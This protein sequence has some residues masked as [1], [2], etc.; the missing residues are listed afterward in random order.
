LLSIGSFSGLSKILETNDFISSDKF[1]D[2]SR[3]EPRITYTKTD[4]L[5]MDGTWR[6]TLQKSL[7]S[8]ISELKDQVL[9]FGHADQKITSSE[10]KL[11]A[12]FS[13]AK[14]IFGTNLATVQ[15]LSEILPLGLTNNS[16]ESELH[17]VLGN[18]NHIA[19][20][21][22]LLDYPKDKFDF[23]VYVNFTIENNRGVRGKVYSLLSKLPNTYQL[24]IDNPSMSDEGRVNYLANLRRSNFVLCP[25][26]NGMDTH[27]LWETLYMGGVPVVVRSKYMD[28]LYNQLPLV[29]LNSWADLSNPLILER[30]WLE[31]QEFQWDDSILTQTYW[32][33]KISMDF[34]DA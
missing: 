28:P 15:G 12:R 4:F 33:S 8:R 17:D 7:I 3:T 23:S 22:A 18:T 25:E 29:R 9:I 2:Y 11:W 24:K 13:G 10:V 21:N 14:R 30:K 6:S 19:L 27:R 20:A 31:V 16:G 26:G 1:L 5:Y 32:L 34:S